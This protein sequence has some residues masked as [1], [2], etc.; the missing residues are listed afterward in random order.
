MTVDPSDM[1]AF[2]GSIQRYG[3][4]FATA[5]RFPRLNSEPPQYP[6]DQEA[7]RDA[8]RDKNKEARALASAPD[9]AGNP[10]TAQPDQDGPQQADHHGGEDEND[11]KACHVDSLRIRMLEHDPDEW[12][13]VF[14]K[15]SCSNKKLD[16][17]RGPTLIMV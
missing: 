17:D 15:R 1:V 12:E 5:W 14:G 10:A 9:T 7:H 4:R 2:R 11:D 3:T 8:G 6:A 13:P 16:H